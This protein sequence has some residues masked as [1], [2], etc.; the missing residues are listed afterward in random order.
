MNTPVVVHAHA[1]NVFG[2]VETALCAIASASS[3]GPVKHR[4]VLGWDG[5]LASELRR[6]GAAVEVIGASRLSR[7]WTVWRARR[8]LRRSLQRSPAAAV[9]F[10]STWALAVYG[11]AARQS[12]SRVACW[13]H[14]PM[15]RG[16]WLDRRAAT[17]GPDVWCA[18]S[19]YSAALSTWATGGACTVVHPPL[20]PP[21]LAESDG[22]D[23]PDTGERKVILCAARLDP[24]KGH[25]VL[26]DA[27][28]RLRHRSDWV[29]WIAGVAPPG[30]D[31][32]AAVLRS[33][34]EAL[35]IAAN[36]VW[37][38]ER[39]DIPALLKRSW[40]MCQPNTVP[41]SFGL[42]FAEAL[43]CGVPVVTSDIGAAAVVVPDSCGIRCRPHDADAVA[44]AVGLLLSDPSLRSSLSQAGPA[45][46]GQL[47]DP[48]LQTARLV[49]SMGIG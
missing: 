32:Y 7:P 37:L 36:V 10:H 33:R 29:C 27:L 17:F 3:H 22:G 28:A 2:G 8:A 34:A 16:S 4:F 42:S 47:C 12:G 6:L 23:L 48:A 24:D 26:L 14:A 41:E 39:R 40:L 21:E 11:P 49:R 25:L 9:L 46:I 1:G 38:G 18:N 30:R 20:P 5:R 35:G 19:E 15:S 43:S 31:A 44:R 45:H 13:L